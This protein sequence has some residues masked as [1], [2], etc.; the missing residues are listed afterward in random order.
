M[1]E[2]SEDLQEAMEQT[3]SLFGRGKHIDKAERVVDAMHTDK[4]R[5]AVEGTTLKNFHQG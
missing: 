2:N 1:D 5:T 4:I 3:W